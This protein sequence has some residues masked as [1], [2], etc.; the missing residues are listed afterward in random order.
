MTWRTFVRRTVTV[1]LEKLKCIFNKP[2]FSEMENGSV[3]KTPQQWV[4]KLYLEEKGFGTI[5]RRMGWVAKG[6]IA[7]TFGISSMTH[8]IAVLCFPWRPSCL[9]MAFDKF[10]S[11]RS[12]SL[13]D[14]SFIGKGFCST[15]L[16]QH[17][18]TFMYPLILVLCVSQSSYDIGNSMYVIPSRRA[19]GF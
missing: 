8:G 9:S 10:S 3:V 17:F 2:T 15:V 7:P 6:V 13:S 19:L 5:L 14:L 11:W 4:I 12:F 18:S 16:P 1:N